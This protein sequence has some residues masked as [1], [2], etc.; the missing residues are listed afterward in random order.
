MPIQALLPPLVAV[1]AL[2][3]NDG[4]RPASAPLP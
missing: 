2:A 3:A 4:T 1:L